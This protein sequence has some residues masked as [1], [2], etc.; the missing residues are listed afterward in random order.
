VVAEDTAEK[1]VLDRVLGGVGGRQRHVITKSVGEA[2]QHGTRSLPSSRRAGS[3]SRSSPAGAASPG[4]LRVDRQRASSH[5]TRMTVATAP[6]PPR[7]RA[8]PGWYPSVE[9]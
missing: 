3:A 9:K 1:G 5:E 6:P 2:E 8:M 4:H 7:Q